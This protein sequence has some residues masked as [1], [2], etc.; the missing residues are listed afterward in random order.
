MDIGY[1]ANWRI[2]G[3][4]SRKNIIRKTILPQVEKILLDQSVNPDMLKLGRKETPAGFGEKTFDHCLALI[5]KDDFWNKDM[6]LQDGLAGW[7]MS[8]LTELDSD[9]SWFLLLPNDFIPLKNE[10]LPV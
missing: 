1:Y 5:T 4:S 7:G 2:S 9:D 10:S 8:F 6:G 3:N